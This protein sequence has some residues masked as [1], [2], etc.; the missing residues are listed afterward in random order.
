[1]HGSVRSRGPGTLE[2]LPKYLASDV[3]DCGGPPRQAASPFDLGQ[4][5]RSFGAHAM[6]S[7]T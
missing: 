1:M 3:P 6:L 7:R 5:Q 4:R 2:P